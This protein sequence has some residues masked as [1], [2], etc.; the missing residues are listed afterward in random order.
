MPR[1][2]GLEEDVSLENNTSTQENDVKS[3]CPGENVIA[4]N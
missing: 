4:L 2:V 1:D 3:N